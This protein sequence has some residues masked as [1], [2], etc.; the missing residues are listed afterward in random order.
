M[1]L[2]EAVTV[3]V[4]AAIAKAI[5]K[6]WVKDSTLGN[7]ISSNLIDL[8]KGKTADVLAQRR[9]ER[10]FESIGE[11]VGEN[12]L[13]LFESEGARLDEGE[14]CAIAYAVAETFNTARLSSEL[15]AEHNLQPTTLVLC[16]A[17]SDG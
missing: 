9:G 16:Y 5:L 1:P 15:L 4:G 7:D 17:S 11:K 13:P 12:L 14:R 6:L 2:L 10:Q 3:E 8:F